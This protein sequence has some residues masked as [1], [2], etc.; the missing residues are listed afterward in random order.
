MQKASVDKRG[1]RSSD[2][3][4]PE[5]NNNDRHVYR[6][7]FWFVRYFYPNFKSVDVDKTG[8]ASRVSVLSRAARVACVRLASF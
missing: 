1:D 6:I 2:R 8:T 7:I 3:Y 4:V 5:Y